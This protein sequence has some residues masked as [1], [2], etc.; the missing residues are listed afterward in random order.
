MN[1][2][3]PSPDDLPFVYLYREINAD[4]VLTRDRHIRA[5]GARSVQL[6]ALIHVREYARPAY[7]RPRVRSSPCV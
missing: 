2:R 4:A 1:K 3:V 7:I 6:E 5:M